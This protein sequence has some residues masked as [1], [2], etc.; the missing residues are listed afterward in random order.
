[1][2]CSLYELH[3]LDCLATIPTEAGKRWHL[4]ERG[5]RLVA[6]ANCMHIRTLTE[7]ADDG[8]EIETSTVVQRGE[9]WLVQRI[10]HTAG[11]Y[12]YFARLAMTARK[13]TGQE[14]CWWETGVMCE[15]RYRVGEQWYNLKPDA[16]LGI[17]DGAAAD[18][19]LAGV[20]S[21]HHERA[22]SGGQVHLLPT[23]TRIDSREWAREDARLPRLLCVAPDIA[24]ERRTQRVAQ[25]RAPLLLDWWC[26]RPRRRC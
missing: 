10:Q 25:A 2:R 23:R 12:S 3:Q 8:A 19:L 22:R 11:I 13:E 24:Q 14:L 18:A 7:M 6:A 26:G 21:W 9:A 1:M 20:G 4:C 5:L 17:P 15:R 16:A